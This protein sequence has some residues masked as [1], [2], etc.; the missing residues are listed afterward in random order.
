VLPAPSDDSKRSQYNQHIIY[1]YGS[2][3]RT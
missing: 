2:K 3:L 1:G